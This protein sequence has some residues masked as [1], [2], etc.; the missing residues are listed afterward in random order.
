MAPPGFVRR[1]GGRDGLPGLYWSKG[2]LR[3][4]VGWWRWEARGQVQA[5][6]ENYEVGKQQDMSPEERDLHKCK[7]THDRAARTA[8]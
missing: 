5:A 1:G 8:D 6:M 7:E 4:C 2:T 3:R